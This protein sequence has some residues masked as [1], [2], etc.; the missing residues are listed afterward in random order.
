MFLSDTKIKESLKLPWNN[1]SEDQSYQK[2]IEQLTED[3]QKQLFSKYEA[4]FTMFSYSMTTKWNLTI[5]IQ[6]ITLMQNR[7]SSYE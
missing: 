4:D 5:Y 7:H 3:E 1:K 6:C 2:Y